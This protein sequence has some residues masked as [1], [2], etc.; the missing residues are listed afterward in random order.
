METYIINEQNIVIKKI[1]INETILDSKILEGSIKDML[2]NILTDKFYNNKFIDNKIN[3]I[4]DKIKDIYKKDI[5]NNKIFNLSY[6]PFN[7]F[8]IK[9]DYINHNYT[10]KWIIPIVDEK[11]TLFMN[12]VIINKYGDLKQIMPSNNFDKISEEEYYNITFKDKFIKKDNKLHIGSKLSDGKLIYTELNNNNLVDETEINNDIISLKEEIF[13]GKNI[14]VIS[15]ID[16]YP[17]KNEDLDIINNDFKILK[18]CKDD[19]KCY[20]VNINSKKEIIEKDLIENIYDI[21]NSLKNENINVTDYLVLEPRDLLNTNYNI[22]LGNKISFLNEIINIEPLLLDDYFNL[23]NLENLPVKYNIITKEKFYSSY[24]YD[25]LNIIKTYNNFDNCFNIRDIKKIYNLYSYDLNKIPECYIEYIKDKLI[26]N[27]R[28]YSINNSDVPLDL[29]LMIDYYNNLKNNNEI[30]IEDLNLLYNQKNIL[31]KYET[32]DNGLLYDLNI[33]I[34]YLNKINKISKVN[35]LENILLEKN[36]NEDLIIINK[37]NSLELYEKDILKEYIH[38]EINTE[39]YL[40]EYNDLLNNLYKKKEELF[41]KY[42][43]LFSNNSEKNKLNKIKYDTIIDE[44]YDLFSNKVYIY[45]LIYR[46]N[47]DEDILFHKINHYKYKSNFYIII[48]K[49]KRKNNNLILINNNIYKYSSSTDSIELIEKNINNFNESIKNIDKDLSF[50]KVNNDIINE[51]IETNKIKYEDINDINSYYDLINNIE[52]NNHIENINKDLKRKIIRQ[53]YYN[54]LLDKKVDF[55]G[56]ISEVQSLEKIEYVLNNDINSNIRENIIKYLLNYDI[57]K[58]KIKE[59]KKHQIINNIEKSDFNTDYTLNVKNISKKIEKL[60]KE[61]QKLWSPICRYL[62]E[63]ELVTFISENTNEYNRAYFKLIEL[64]LNNT[65]IEKTDFKLLALAEAPGNFVKCVKNLRYKFDTNWNNYDIFTLLSHENLITQGNF[66]KMFEDN[67][68]GNKIKDFDGDLTNPDNIEEYIKSNKDKADLITADG[69]FDKQDY[70]LEE[71]EHLPLFLGECIMAILNQKEDGIFILKMY[72]IIDINSVNL[73]YL[74]QAFYKNISIIKPYNSRPSNT[75][76]YIYCENFIGLPLEIYDIIKNKLYNIL[77]EINKKTDKYIYFNIF[78][79]FKY[80]INFNL[81]IKEFNNSI[82][83]KTQSLYIETVYDIINTKNYYNKDIIKKYFSNNSIFNLEKLFDESSDDIGYFIKNIENCIKLCLYMNIPIKSY[84][85]EY[86]NTIKKKKSCILNDNC[87][88][89]PFYFKEMY[90]INNEANDFKK[91][92]KIKDFVKKYCISYDDNK[93]KIIIHKIVQIVDTFLKNKSISNIN[94]II[95]NKLKDNLNNF[96]Q[97]IILLKEI[98]KITDIYKIFYTY[99]TSIISIINNFQNKIRNLLGYYLCKFTYIPLY[100][101][102]ITID[103]PIEQIETYGILYKS[104]YICFYSGDELGIEEYDEYMGSI[105]YRS[106]IS[107]SIFE[108]EKDISLDNNI[109][110]SLDL[111]WNTSLSENDTKYN[112]CLFIMNEYKNINPDFDLDNNMKINI[113]K[114]ISKYD[115]YFS[116]LNKEILINL[117]KIKIFINSFYDIFN[118]TYELNKHLD[119]N[120]RAKKIHPTKT[121]LEEENLCQIYKLINNDLNLKSMYDIFIEPINNKYTKITSETNICDENISIPVFKKKTTDPHKIFEDFKIFEDI[122]LL[123]LIKTNVIN[124][125]YSTIFYT[126]S[127]LTLYNNNFNL[128]KSSNKDNIELL[129]EN[130]YNIEVKLIHKIYSTNEKLFDNIFYNIQSDYKNV[131]TI[132]SDFSIDTN[133]SNLHKIFNKH[134]DDKWNENYKRVLK[135]DSNEDILD[136]LYTKFRNKKIYVYDLLNDSNLI[137]SKNII[138]LN[139]FNTIKNIENKSEY[140]KYLLKKILSNKNTSYLYNSKIILDN[141]YNSISY[142]SN[143]NYFDESINISNTIKETRYELTSIDHNILFNNKNNFILKPNYS[144]YNIQYKYNSEKDILNNA[145]KFLLLYIFEDVSSNGVDISHLRGIKRIFDYNNKLYSEYKDDTLYCSYTG[146]NKIEILNNIL[147]KSN[148]E[149][150]ELYKSILNINSTI[151]NK[152]HYIGMNFYIKEPI[153]GFYGLLNNLTYKI[154]KYETSILYNFI[155]KFINTNQDLIKLDNLK[156]ILINFHN[157]PVHYSILFLKNDTYIT[158]FREFLDTSDM[159][160]ITVNYNILNIIDKI[161]VFNDTKL[162]KIKTLY[163][164]FNKQTINNIDAELNYYIKEKLKNIS[165]IL[166]NFNLLDN[167]NINSK[168]LILFIN[169]IKRII[170]TMINLP[171]KSDKKIFTNKYKF[172]KKIV[173]SEDFKLLV[174]I[175]EKNDLFS[176]ILFNNSNINNYQIIFTKILQEFDYNFDNIYC[177]NE[178]ISCKLINYKILSIINLC[179]NKLT[180]HT[181]NIHD[182]Y[183]HKFYWNYK[184][185]KINNLE[186]L[187]NIDNSSI[188]KK[189]TIDKSTDDTY[190]LL[191]IKIINVCYSDINNYNNYFDE[192]FKGQ[193]NIIDF[194]NENDIHNNG[195]GDFEYQNLSKFNEDLALD[196][197]EL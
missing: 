10:H 92:S 110:E 94:H 6:Q 9:Y 104:K 114:H 140:K 129:I 184:S 146:L 66:M 158:E 28:Y 62:N 22:Y 148:T 46:I 73:L 29:Y 177:N 64:L 42:D 103:D 85:I 188:S 82:V 106:I 84:F 111:N 193:S 125:Y 57:N 153:F 197:E 121:W 39:L 171:F 25:Y 90:N 109:L 130:F 172:L 142:L 105:S 51:N 164:N 165:N 86:Y 58:I 5:N 168:H 30:L 192:Y 38:S 115:M 195:G 26:D 178:Y 174:K 23:N 61:K 65:I 24:N 155:N 20:Y 167:I 179:I 78:E 120:K 80:D 99:T 4:I 56:D 176:T 52:L 81:N 68:F 185:N 162:N 70:H 194:N 74:L 187:F 133:I 117:N 34:K 107:E 18:K 149:I 88:Y 40:I 119:I 175:I 191:F 182:N 59:L 37:Y 183:Y 137:K 14:N 100:P 17:S 173:S 159:L 147:E 71:Y 116:T 145:I 43:I 60:S 49:N 150:I 47:S 72:D 132:S 48:P 196:I 45:S 79:D 113:L 154:T 157:N 55:D 108:H 33:Y 152:T 2:S 69:G 134:F 7:K 112:I 77:K 180:S 63:Y 91:I 21:R 1:Y 83:L 98:C 190:L 50:N 138:D 189:I 44:L 135:K 19:N 127:L 118:I 143:F 15:N 93:D 126:L 101:K 36:I 12:V 186:E 144:S 67:I 32:I 31:N 75:E 89:Y 122:I 3:N 124:N 128:E 141:F 13:E 54:K 53:D 166:P 160:P 27:I 156:N 163:D 139:I 170:S 131:I 95:F 96:D 8:N 11:K 16:M 151:I 169:N 181:F 161:L 102:Y 87:N 136:S 76:K 41:F 35:K 97:L 123:Y